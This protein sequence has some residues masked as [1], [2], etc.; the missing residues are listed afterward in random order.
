[1]PTQKH[2]PNTG[3]TRL[4]IPV[5]ASLFCT[6]SSKKTNPAFFQTPCQTITFSHSCSY[7]FTGKELDPET[8]YSYFGARYLDHTPLTLWLSV[9]PMAD[10]YPSISPYAYCAWNPLKLVD[11][12]GREL[13][14]NDDIIIK[15]KNNSSLTI[16]TSAVNLTIHTDK[17]FHGNHVVDAGSA[18][19]AIGYE[20]GVDGAG[21]AVFQTSGKAYMQSVMFFGGKYDGYWYDYLGGEAQ[22]N[23]SNIAEGTVGIH[24]NWF[25]GVYTGKAKEF[26]PKSFAGRYYGVDVG[27]SSNLL[28]AGLSIDGS[29]ARSMKKD[30]NII[31]LGAS[32]VVGPQIDLG[33]ELVG[34]Y[35]GSNLGG[36]V[37]VT[38]EIETKERKIWDRVGNFLFHKPN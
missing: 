31:A 30:W 27:A 8:G 16:V 32:F 7:S 34:V 36:T 33:T 13:V 19:I 26:N 38:P 17:D 12:N 14:S 11:P 25:I 2:A 3:K 10:K 1:M 22:L 37:L 6:F 24:K 20:V 28:L 35:G 4:T 18:K 9:D 29:W 5:S 21:S 23:I 15:G